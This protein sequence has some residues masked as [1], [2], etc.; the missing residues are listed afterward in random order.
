MK[1][2]ISTMSEWPD[3]LRL[4]LAV[5]NGRTTPAYQLGGKQWRYWQDGRPVNSHVSHWMPLPD[6]PEVKS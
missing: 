1:E 3:E 5:V 6:P 2:W 4:V